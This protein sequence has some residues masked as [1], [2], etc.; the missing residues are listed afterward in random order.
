M[1]YWPLRAHTSL[2]SILG[3]IL[4]QTPSQSLLGKYVI[5]VIPCNSVT[6]YFY[7]LTH[8]DYFTFHFHLQYK[9]T[10]M[11]ALFS[12]SVRP[13]SSYSFEN[14]TSGTSPL[15]SYKAV[16]PPPPLPPPTQGS[17]FIISTCFIYRSITYKIFFLLLQDASILY[18]TLKS[19]TFIIGLDLGYNTMGDEGAEI[20]AQLLQVYV[21]KKQTN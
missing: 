15:A 7:E 18:K 16:T 1:C 12:E 6:F 9:H 10:G 20:I 13:H 19:N 5:F 14:V 4:L 8:G 3:P 21:K 11:F 2:Q 17:F